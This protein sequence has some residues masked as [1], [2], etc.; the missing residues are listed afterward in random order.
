MQQQ[1][2]QQGE[3][4][5]TSQLCF[6]SNSLNCFLLGLS[7]HDYAGQLMWNLCAKRQRTM[8][9][10]LMAP[11]LCHVF[12]R[13]WTQR[14]SYFATSSGLFCSAVFIFLFLACLSSEEYVLCIFLFFRTL[15]IG[16]IDRWSCQILKKLNQWLHQ[17]EDFFVM[18]SIFTMKKWTTLGC[19][20]SSSI[21]T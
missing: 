21:V 12:W 17:L 6:L 10:L 3:L 15:F 5:Y 14:P 19:F 1:H 18:M 20:C 4:F 2:N 9:C 13:W 16:L 8:H 7:Q 11:H